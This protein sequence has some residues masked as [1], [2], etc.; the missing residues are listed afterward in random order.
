MP[1][2][3]EDR[4]VQRLAMC[5]GLQAARYAELAPRLLMRHPVADQTPRKA[6]KHASMQGLRLADTTDPL[7]HLPAAGG[8]PLW[9]TQTPA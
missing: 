4:P 8:T 2:T 7:V 5:G 9:L 1:A 3:C 6:G